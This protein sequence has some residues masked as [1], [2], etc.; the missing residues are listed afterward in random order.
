[1]THHSTRGLRIWALGNTATDGRHFYV[2]RSGNWAEITRY[3]RVVS[4]H[5]G[6]RD[7]YVEDTTGKL[8]P[9]FA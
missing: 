3:L 1:M 5:T 4:Q 8:R 2:V 9:L 6:P 7:L